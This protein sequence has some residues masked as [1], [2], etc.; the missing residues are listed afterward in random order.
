MSE[1]GVKKEERTYHDFLTRRNSVSQFEFKVCVLMSTFS[2][3]YRMRHK[4]QMIE[5]E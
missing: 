1:K 2:R 3:E 5:G 4:W